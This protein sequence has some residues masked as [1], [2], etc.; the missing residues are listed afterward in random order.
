MTLPTRSA[1]VITAIA[2]NQQNFTLPSFVIGGRNA[3]TYTL[4]KITT[5][6][7]FSVWRSE[8]YRIGKPFDVT[9]ITIPVFPKV[10]T[11]MTIIPVLYFDNGTLV[12]TGTTINST[13]YPSKTEIVLT[14]A[15][16]RPSLPNNLAYDGQTGNFTP[17]LTV[18]GGT[19]GATGLIVSDSDQG[20]TG[21]L[22]LS[23]ITGVFVDNE[24]IT[25]TSTGSATVNRPN[26]ANGV[27]GN[28]NFFLEFQV[29]GSALA[30]IGLP[31]F[32]D[33]EQFDV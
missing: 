3:S 24:L 20:A 9:R 27:R 11:N 12:S 14:A 7:S 2:K 21:T 22:T 33:L 17:A 4:Q 6:Y 23:G 26:Y 25:D 13:N 19:S 1:S 28:Q 15:N 32:I 16:F 8:I 30:T 10:G 18:T 29:S 5:S 31:I